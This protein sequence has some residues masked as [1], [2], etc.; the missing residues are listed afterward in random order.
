MRSHSN[1][2]L[3]TGRV[4]HEMSQAAPGLRPVLEP[5][6]SAEAEMGR[7][8]E[9]VAPGGFVAQPGCCPLLQPRCSQAP[10][11][12]VSLIKQAYCQV[13]PEWPCKT[14]GAEGSLWL[15]DTVSCTLPPWAPHLR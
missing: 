11:C 12:R 3:S 2:T 15:W 14:T 10:A 8:S 4:S 7:S 1:S 9:E 5:P 6:F 13:S